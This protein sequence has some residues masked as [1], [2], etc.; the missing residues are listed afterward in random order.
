MT[1]YILSEGADRD[2]DCIWD[3]IAEDSADSADAWI[4]KLFE[5]FDAI[6]K[7]PGIGHTSGMI[8]LIIRFCSG[9]WALT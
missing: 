6:G 9:Q 8:L 7:T 4:A 5:A 1:R 3:Y 2:L